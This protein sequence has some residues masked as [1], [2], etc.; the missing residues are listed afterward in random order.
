[1]KRYILI[2][3]LTLTIG[4]AKKPVTAPVPGSINTLDAW[5]FRIISDAQASITSVKTWEQCTAAGANPGTVTVDGVQQTCD[6]T[7]GAFPMQYKP[8][9]NLAITSLN[10]ASAAGK[11]YHSG[12]SNDTAGLTNA[13]NQLAQSITQL[14]SQIGAKQ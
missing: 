6:P 4:C 5:A 2:L 1:M 10:T 3:M 7:A 9:L 14:M 12:A 8:Q 13:V 11:A